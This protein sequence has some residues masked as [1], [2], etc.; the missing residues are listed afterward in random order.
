M[1][2]TSLPEKMTKKKKGIIIFLLRL[3]YVTS[4]HLPA[5]LINSELFPDHTLYPQ[6]EIF[7]TFVLKL[8]VR[9]S[10]DLELFRR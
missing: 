5:L 4:L 1:N 7:V 6:A 8:H 9:N 3:T 2:D 10:L